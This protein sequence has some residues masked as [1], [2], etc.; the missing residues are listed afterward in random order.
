MMKK[1]KHTVALKTFLAIMYLLLPVLT[2]A[3]QKFNLIGFG[4]QEI[5]D[6]MRKEMT[7]F[8]P[9]SDK[10]SPDYLYMKYVDRNDM[11]TVY[12]FLED[13]GQCSWVRYIGDLSLMKEVRQ[14]YDEHLKKENENSW[15]EK[16]GRTTY[17]YRLE[18]KEWFFLIEIKPEN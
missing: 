12:F 7:D 5:R 10:P 15:L 1:R 13:N 16:S 3:G 8:S 4:R 11:R 14:R 18:E 17:R 2:V 6:Y 9:S